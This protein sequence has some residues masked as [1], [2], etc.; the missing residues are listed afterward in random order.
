[1]PLIVPPVSGYNGL[2]VDGSYVNN[3]PSDVMTDMGANIILSIDIGS[4]STFP[5]MNYVDEITGF[6]ILI[7]Q[8]A[9]KDKEYLTLYSYFMQ[10]TCKKI[11]CH[12]F[13][14]LH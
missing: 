9:R 6:R 4:K 12:A 10:L 2:F 8:I 7:D 14:F 11:S 5:K 1:M 3:V 13:D